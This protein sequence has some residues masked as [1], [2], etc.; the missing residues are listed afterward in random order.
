MSQTLRADKR[1]T[2]LFYRNEILFYDV[3]QYVF[4]YKKVCFRIF[5]D[6]ACT[7]MYTMFLW[8]EDAGFGFMPP[9]SCTRPS[10]WAQMLHTNT[11]LLPF[12][13]VVVV[14][15]GPRS[16]HSLHVCCVYI[17]LL[18][19]NCLVFVLLLHRMVL[20]S[21]RS[22]ENKK[23]SQR[24]WSTGLNGKTLQLSTKENTEEEIHNTTKQN[25]KSSD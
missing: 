3:H 7:A 5:I 21:E 23:R 20:R 2:L 22:K 25:Y 18:W 1:E 12:C 15:S 17:V 4:L 10:C 13:S 16:L 11:N 9:L 14:V 6:L 8:G 24:R 19:V